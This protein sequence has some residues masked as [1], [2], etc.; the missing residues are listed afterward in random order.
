MRPLVALL[1]LSICLVFP[2]RADAQGLWQ[3][4]TIIGQ[5][6]GAQPQPRSEWV[7][8]DTGGSGG[9]FGQGDIRQKLQDVVFWNEKVGW[10]CG[11]GGVFRTGDGG[12]TW[13]RMKPKGGWYHMAMPGPEEIWLLEGQH[14]GGPGKVWLWQTADG[15]RSWHEH[16]A[17]KLAGYLDLYCRGNERWVLCGGFP[18]YRSEDGGKTWK[19][20]KFGGLLQAAQKIAIPA[21]VRTDDGFVVYVLGSYKES[22][23]FIKSADGGRKW[24]VVALPDAP[25]HHRYQCYF[26][27]SRMG[28][29]SGPEGQLLFTE[30][31]GETWQ[32]RDLPTNQ[33]VTALWHDQL[34]RGFAAVDNSDFFHFRQT[35]YETPDAGKTWTAVLGGAKHVSALFALG[36]GRLWAVGDVPGFVPNDLVAICRG[37]SR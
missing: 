4:H 32:R 24:V 5:T 36:P 11:Y 34:G 29:V 28:F 16:L 33:W 27:T 35:L 8:L 14:P 2:P 12:L 20:E 25:R 9:G 21:D 31:G 30:D 3:G 23:R 7:V 10:A 1:I 17:G 15:G 6:P 13:T 26:A 18:S 19:Q 22:W 37:H